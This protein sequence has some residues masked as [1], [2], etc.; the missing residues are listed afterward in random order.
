MNSHSIINKLISRLVFVLVALIAVSVGGCKDNKEE[1]PAPASDYNGLKYTSPGSLGVKLSHRFNASDFV[2]NKA[3]VTDAGDTVTFDMLRYYFSNVQLKNTEGN[4]IN[5]GNYNLVDFED[6]ASFTFNIA[7]VPAGT[8]SKIRFY[9][10]VDSIAN[11]SG[12]NSGDL[13]PVKGMYWAWNSGYIMAKLEGHSNVCKTLHHAFE[14]HIGGYMPPYNAARNVALKIPEYFQVG[15]PSLPGITITADI[16]AW[17]TN[18][19]DLTKVNSIMI[20][21]KDA[22]MMADKYSKMFFIEEV[23]FTP[24]QR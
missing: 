2:F 14:F 20:P 4:W 17:F 6:A 16:A 3:Y 12:A 23:F 8:Y 24:L 1:A 10:G 21:G 9:M 11:T 18:D 19:L 5:L 15:R 22:A 7:N 13:D